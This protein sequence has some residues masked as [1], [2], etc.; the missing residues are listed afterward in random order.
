MRPAC[1]VPDIEDS[2]PIF[3]PDIVCT[4]GISMSIS[5]A[6]V[7]PRNRIADGGKR[8]IRGLCRI[9]QIRK[10]AATTDIHFVFVGPL[11]L[12]QEP[13]GGLYRL[14]R[15]LCPCGGRLL[16][17]HVPYISGLFRQD[18]SE[19]RR[20]KH[21]DHIRC[22]RP[23]RNCNSEQDWIVRCLPELQD[24]VLVFPPHNAQYNSEKAWYSQ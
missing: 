4:A 9:P 3:S 8:F 22:R 7:F 5:W 12:V 20:Y 1:C 15:R 24:T 13:I 6:L 19:Y 16:H 21:V 10:T 18:K 11:D 23:Y 17:P 14:P 2:Q